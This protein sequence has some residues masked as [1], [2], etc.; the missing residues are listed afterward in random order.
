MSSLNQRLQHNNNLSLYSVDFIF[1]HFQ[2]EFQQ[3]IASA[4]R[5]WCVPTINSLL[6]NAILYKFLHMNLTAMKTS[7]FGKINWKF[8]DSLSKTFEKLES[9]SKILEFLLNF[10]KQKQQHWFSTIFSSLPS[11]LDSIEC[12]PIEL[13][14]SR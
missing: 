8:T 2:H 5:I 12:W 14:A 1:F 6:K 10:L 13:N 11:N 9:L 7:S 4:C 3:F